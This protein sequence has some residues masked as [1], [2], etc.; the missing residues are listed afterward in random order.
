MRILKP[1]D[2]Q[3]LG[4]HCLWL[5]YFRPLV[6]CHQPRQL[7]KSKCSTINENSTEFMTKTF[8]FLKDSTLSNIRKYFVKKKSFLKC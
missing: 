7:G 2:D 5:I 6:R 3:A 8:I 1:N 4:F